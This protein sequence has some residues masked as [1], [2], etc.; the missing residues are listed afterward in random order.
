MRAPGCITRVGFDDVRPAHV[1]VG[2]ASLA[3]EAVTAFECVCLMHLMT[4]EC[5]C[6]MHLMTQ[7]GTHTVRLTHDEQKHLKV[8]EKLHKLGFQLRDSDMASHSAGCDNLLSESLKSVMSSLCTQECKKRK[9]CHYSC[10][11]KTG[12]SRQSSSMKQGSLQL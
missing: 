7:D 3:S 2:C 4:F 1:T 11:P 8:D 12:V 6:L 9:H 5:V 10:K